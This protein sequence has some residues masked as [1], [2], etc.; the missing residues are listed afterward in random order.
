[1]KPSSPSKSLTGLLLLMS[2]LANIPTLAKQPASVNKLKGPYLGQTPP[3]HTPV[4]FAPGLVSTEHRDYSGSFTPDMQTFY[5]TRRDNQIEKW[6]LQQVKSNNGYWQESTLMPRVGRPI[7]SPDGQTMHLGKKYMQ[8]DR[9]GWSV[10]KSLG[11]MLDRDDWGI[12]RLSS[13][14]SG[15]YVFDDYKNGDVLRISYV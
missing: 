8:R 11:P 3:G 7:L 14:N 4:V 10:I 15:T 9:Q 2:L 13:S 5:F 12:M 6:Y 1:M